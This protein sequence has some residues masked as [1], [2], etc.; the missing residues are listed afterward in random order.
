MPCYNPLTAYQTVGGEVVFNE[1]RRHDISRQLQLA[2][3]Q[4]IGCRLER[5]RQWAIRCMHEASLYEFNCFITLTYDEKNLPEDGSLNYRDFQL[6]MK[7]LRKQ[8][9]LPAS[10]LHAASRHLLTKNKIRFYMCGEYGE[11]NNRPHFHACLFNLDF[12]D[13]VLLKKSSSGHELYTSPTLEK[14]WTKGYSTI[15]ALTFESAAYTARYIMKKIN[16]Q[17]ANKHYENI[18]QE[19]GEITIK[20]SEINNMSRKPGI[21]SQWLEK[22]MTD[23]YPHDYVV[24]RG[25]KNKPPRYY[26]KKL[27]LTN[28]EM[29]D[30]LQFERNKTAQENY[31]DNTPQRLKDKETVAK[32]KINQLKRNTI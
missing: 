3:G 17:Q 19:T 7:R 15:G 20:K 11:I 10:G 32:A 5:S 31:Q 13:K 23:V 16:G 24:T 30:T 4:C 12:K 26:D 21:A 29:Y 2:C 6:F 9:A 28:P 27:Q 14:I 22:Y 25:Q 18:N 8:T 1:T